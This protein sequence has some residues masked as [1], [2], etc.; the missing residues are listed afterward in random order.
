MRSPRV[1]THL[2]IA[3]LTGLPRCWSATVAAAHQCITFGAGLTGFPEFSVNL[4]QHYFDTPV[5]QPRGQR[6]ADLTGLRVWHCSRPM[7]H[8]MQQSVLPELHET[9]KRPLRV[10]ELGSGCGLLGIGMAALGEHCVLTDPASPVNFESEDALET[11]GQRTTLEWLQDNVDLNHELSGSRAVARKLVWGNVEDEQ[12]IRDE[13]CVGRDEF[14]LLLGSDLLYNPDQYTSL[15]RS[16]RTFC[17]PSTLALLVY[18]A[19]HP[20]EQRFFD[21]ASEFFDVTRSVIDGGGDTGKPEIR[22][23]TCSPRPTS[24]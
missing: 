6:A 17:S 10:L 20:G 16:M 14:D 15:I 8:H 23:A 21:A 4:R 1:A 9:K 18:Q 7:L 22:L 2:L 24:S 5:P 3:I 11:S 19:R 12:A 13:W